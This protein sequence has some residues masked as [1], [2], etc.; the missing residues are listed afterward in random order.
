MARSLQFDNQLVKL[1]LS[2]LQ[3]PSEDEVW[4]VVAAV[5][6]KHITKQQGV[7][8]VDDVQSIATCGRP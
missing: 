5:V 1:V 2:G 4:D 3:P 6:Q 8:A 7:E